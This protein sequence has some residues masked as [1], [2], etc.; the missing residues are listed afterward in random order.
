MFGEVESERPAGRG[1]AD[2]SRISICWIGDGGVGLDFVRAVA[3]VAELVGIDEIDACDALEAV[4]ASAPV[5]LA[6]SMQVP[7]AAATPQRVVPI[8]ARRLRVHAAGR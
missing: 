7:L 1:D 8:Q 2:G 4:A 5:L 3:R 6:T